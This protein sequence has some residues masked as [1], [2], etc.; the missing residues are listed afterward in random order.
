[1]AAYMM[2]II[3]LCLLLS[4]TQLSLQQTFPN[5]GFGL[6][7][8]SPTADAYIQRYIDPK[9]QDFQRKAGVVFRQ[10]P[11][12]FIV[13]SPKCGTTSLYEALMYHPDICRS[14]EKEPF[15]FIYTQL[16]VQ[17]YQAYHK[18]FPECKDGIDH[19]DASAFYFHL[20]YVPSRIKAFY[21]P[22]HFDK[23]GIV[24][25]LRN[26]SIREF[27]F[28]QHLY[29]DCVRRM[30]KYLHREKRD[31]WSTAKRNTSTLC[32]V[33]S[34]KLLSCKKSFHKAA[35]AD[36]G[37]ALSTFAEYIDN[38]QI[39][40]YQSR[41]ILHIKNWLQYF[42]RD[43]LFIINFEYLTAHPPDALNRI[44]HFWGLNTTGDW[45]GAEDTSGALPSLNN[46]PM[47]NYFAC[48]TKQSIDSHTQKHTQ[49]LYDFM[50]L[51]GGPASEPKFLPFAEAKRCDAFI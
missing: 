33:V 47:K 7:E 1:M 17:G 35:L 46:A 27:S 6:L 4:L 40:L 37:K 28:Y 19:I 51:G 44:V 38:K 42:R 45:W 26:P 29:R 36:P 49:E 23:I 34:C 24:V 12:F 30:K 9:T 41:Y 14:V 2:M 20:P 43:Q 10:K 32:D 16:F 31:G 22:E 50:A 48:E 25:I 18:N 21:A 8:E 15:F 39:D 11:H 13:G 3:H 5:L